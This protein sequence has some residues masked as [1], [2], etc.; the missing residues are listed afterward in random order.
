[1]KKLKG[2]KDIGQNTHV[3][4]CI[5]WKCEKI[6]RK[7]RERE[8]ERKNE[9]VWIEKEKS[10]ESKTNQH[11]NTCNL[12]LKI[13]MI[14]HINVKSTTNHVCFYSWNVYK[15]QLCCDTTVWLYKSMFT[16]TTNIINAFAH[17]LDKKF[18]FLSTFQSK[19][20]RQFPNSCSFVA[21]NIFFLHTKSE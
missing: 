1:M 19:E 2:W 17:F 20:I 14:F 13:P 16:N 5:F 11:L 6:Q 8:S 4:F 10:D 15:F 12:R 3:A 18:Y 21:F 7:K 9:N